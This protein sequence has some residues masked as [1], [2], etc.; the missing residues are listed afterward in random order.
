M[1]YNLLSAYAVFS[2]LYDAKKSIYDLLTHCIAMFIREKLKY[3]F[4]LINFTNDFNSFYGFSLPQ[5]VMKKVLSKTEGVNFDKQNEQ[6]LIDLKLLPESKIKDFNCYREETEDVLDNLCIFIEKKNKKSLS[7]LEKENLYTDF[8]DYLLKTTCKN[9]INLKFITAFLI[10]NENNKRYKDILNSI[11]E[12]IIIYSGITTSLMTSESI[13]DLRGSWNTNLSIY[14]DTEILFHLAGYNGVYFKQKADDLFNLIKEINKKDRYIELKY[15]P[16]TLQDI[17]NYFYAAEKTIETGKLVVNSTAM[18]YIVNGCKNPSDIR[19]K[20]QQFMTYLRNNQISQDETNFYIEKNYKYNIESGELNI[21]PYLNYINI[22][23]EGKNSERLRNIKFILITGK[24]DILK[25]S[26]NPVI[27]NEG[28][29]P[30]AT[31]LDYLTEH[32]W[33]LL[34]KGFGK[35]KSLSSF[36]VFNRAKIV[37]S[38]LISESVSEKYKELNKK[39]TNGDITEGDVAEAVVELRAESRKPEEIKV[40]EID[41]LLNVLS[42]DSLNC[43]IHD[44]QMQKIEY[45]NTI[46]EQNDKIKD[47]EKFKDIV[48]EQEKKR[49]K[50]RKLL[51]CTKKVFIKLIPSFCAIIASWL[52]AYFFSTR[53]QEFYNTVALFLSCLGIFNVKNILD[54]IKFLKKDK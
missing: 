41:F 42:E 27:Y 15:F 38:S 54:F 20:K 29:I 49:E 24:S 30:R 52:I 33:F 3:S 19:L 31:S 10:E 47:L 36:D 22:L 7:Q 48:L 23:R 11:K 46:K 32:F 12:G 37:F 14:L 2:K 18:S 5:A 25:Q 17:H 28:D 51:L 44:K 50:V 4:E 43:F 13:T 6:Y 1:N 35:S 16:E 26:W 34:N 45:E 39:F 40:N 9:E 53:N 21:S 8:S